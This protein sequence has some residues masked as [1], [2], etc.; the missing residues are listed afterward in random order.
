MN[1]CSNIIGSAGSCFDDPRANILYT[2]AVSWFI[3]RYINNVSQSERTDK[4]DVI[5]MDAL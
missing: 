4:Y 1:D 2:D 3:D 5:I